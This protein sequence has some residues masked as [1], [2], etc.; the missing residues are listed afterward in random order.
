MRIHLL[1]KDAQTENLG[2]TVHGLTETGQ[3][4]S[5]DPQAKLVKL[6][7]TLGRKRE[8]LVEKDGGEIELGRERP[9]KGLAK[10]PGKEPGKEPGNRTAERAQEKDAEEIIEKDPTEE[11]TETGLLVVKKESLVVR[12]EAPVVRKEAL[13]VRRPGAVETTPIVEETKLIPLFHLQS[14]SR[15]QAESGFGAQ[16]HRCLCLQK[17]P[18]S[19]P[20]PHLRHQQHHLLCQMIPRMRPP[21]TT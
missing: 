1:A 13:V 16:Y 7:N 8:K 4:P 12:K 3:K 6:Q 18:T 5:K 9:E 14:I 19:C 11:E 17:I 20:Y 2:G 21:N 10:D 15:K